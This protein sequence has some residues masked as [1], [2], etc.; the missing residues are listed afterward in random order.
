MPD[1]TNPQVVRFANE[2]ARVLCD[3][4]ATF[5]NTAK[6]ATTVW[7]GQGLGALVPNTADLIADGSDVDGRGRITGAALTSLKA[8]LDA[9]IA[10]AEAG[11]NAKRNAFFAAAVNPRG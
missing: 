1:I 4:W 6:T 2:H 5:Y 8:L 10:D 7:A 11:G 9:F 3:A